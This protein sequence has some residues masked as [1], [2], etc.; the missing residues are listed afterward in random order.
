VCVQ[1]MAYSEQL[2]LQR[3]M[4]SLLKLNAIECLKVKQQMRYAQH[5][6]RF[7]VL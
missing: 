5:L 1:V 2:K 3:V 4:C 7:S 6:V